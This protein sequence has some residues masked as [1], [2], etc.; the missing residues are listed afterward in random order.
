MTVAGR[1][2]PSIR[3]PGVRGLRRLFGPVVLLSGV[4]VLVALA[5]VAGYLTRGEEVERLDR[6]LA[7]L[8]S[9]VGDGSQALDDATLR[10]LA[11]SAEATDLRTQLDASERQVTALST[12][13]ASLE[14][15]A[16][17]S[18]NLETS[19]SEL[20]AA[21]DQLQL[22]YAAT[23]AELQRWSTV[24]EI[25]SFGPQGNPLLINEAADAWVAQP[26]CTGSMEPAIGCDDLLVV[27]SPG[28]TDL[29]VGDIIT[30][31]RPAA[32]CEGTVDGAF[33]LHRI[34]RVVSA[35]GNGLQFE[36]R[37]DANAAPD[38][39]LVPVASVTSKVLA[40]IHDSKLP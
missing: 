12:E 17:S 16:Q 7:A 28:I 8:T 32:G 24:R 40:V 21:H 34:T 22:D 10:V 3:R 31:K 14:A 4:S 30:F 36:T 29:D 35:N 27:Y 25:E 38:P 6:Q 19:L 37:G 11:L 1:V 39:C 20:V 18:V 2:V 5:A 13:L 33:L 26:V 15:A 23:L 9:E